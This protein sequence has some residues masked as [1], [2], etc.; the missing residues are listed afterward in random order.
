MTYSEKEA[1]KQLPESSSGPEFSGIG[2]Y[3]HIELIF[4]IDGLFTDVPSIPD[5]RITSRL[6]T[7]FKVHA[8]I[9][10]TE[11]KEIH[12]RRNLPWWRSKIIQKYRN[13]TCIWQKTLSFLNDRYKVD[14]D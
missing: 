14:K 2:E 3:D 8:S 13:D 4:Y 12:G 7:A 5:Y 10:Y 9:W 6:N 11:I 1:L